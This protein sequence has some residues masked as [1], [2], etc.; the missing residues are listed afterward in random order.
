VGDGAEPGPV[1]FEPGEERRA[2]RRAHG[3]ERSWKNH[4][5]RKTGSSV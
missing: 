3:R 2:R 4:D 5:D 1:R